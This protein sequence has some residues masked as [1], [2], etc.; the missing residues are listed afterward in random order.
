MN[1]LAFVAA[2]V[3]VSLP[4]WLLILLAVAGGTSFF[5]SVR[6]L[7][8]LWKWSHLPLFLAVIETEKPCN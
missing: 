6:V 4:R 3:I 8:Q 7:Y 1:L 5:T 2:P